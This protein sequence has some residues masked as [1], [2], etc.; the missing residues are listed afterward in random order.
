MGRIWEKMILSVIKIRIQDFNFL[1]WINFRA[2]LNFGPHPKK[3]N[4]SGIKISQD[5]KDTKEYRN[6]YNLKYKDAFSLPKKSTNFVLI[7]C[8]SFGELD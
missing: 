3:F 4:F 5:I 6:D 1:S 2:T 7:Y 8:V